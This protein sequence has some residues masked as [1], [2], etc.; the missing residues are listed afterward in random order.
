VTATRDVPSQDSLVYKECWQLRF[1]LKT[2]QDM[3]RTMAHSGLEKSVPLLLVFVSEYYHHHQQQQQHKP[4]YKGTP[5]FTKGK[6]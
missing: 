5:I 1:E 4:E 2:Y 3:Y 6:S